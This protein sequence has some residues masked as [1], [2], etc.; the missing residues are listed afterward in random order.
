M[1][2]AR[3]LK[4]LAQPDRFIHEPARLAILTVLAS[5]QSAEFLF[6]QRLTNLTKGNLSV[7]LSKLEESG[8]IKI[9]KSFVGKKPC[10]EACLTESGA[11][12]LTAYWAAMDELRTKARNAARK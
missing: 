3:P 5:C 4:Q 2:L 8:L 1:P 10:T 9:E 6:L 12:A 11:E 7:Q